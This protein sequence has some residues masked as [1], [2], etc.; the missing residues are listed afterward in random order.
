[1]QDRILESYTKDFSVQ[2]E[3]GNLN[4]QLLFSYFVNFCVI[5]RHTGAQLSMDNFDVDGGQ[6]MGLDGIAVLINGRP[7]SAKETVDHF[8]DKLGRLNVEFIFIQSKTSPKFDGGDLGTFLLGVKQFFAKAPTLKENANVA[9]Y[10]DLKEYIYDNSLY[11]D[12]P[13]IC[14][15][16]YAST[17]K[18]VDDPHLQGVVAA[19]VSELNKTNL[20]SAVKFNA[21]D[22]D[23]L[24]ATYRELRNKIEKEVIFERRTVLPKIER[25]KEAYLGILPAT[26][27][28][29]LITDSDGDIQRSLYYDN[30]RDFQGKN[31]VNEEMSETLASATSSDTFVLLNNGVTIVAKSVN[32]VG[33]AFKITDFQIVNGCQTSH[34]LHLNRDGLTKKIFVPVKLIVTDDPEVTNSIIK[35]TN[36]QTEVKVEAFESLAPFHR[37]LE[38]FYASFGKGP[39]RRLYY[40]RR[41]KQYENTEVKPKDIIS[42]ATQTKS[43]LAMF[44]NDPHSTPRYYG[45]LLESNRG[46]IYLIEHSPFVYYT[47]ALAFITID[48]LCRQGQVPG[49]C[50]QFKYHLTMLFR[51]EITKEIPHLSGKKA[52]DLCEKIC[53]VLWDSPSTLKVLN[54]AITVLDNKLKAF[55]GNHLL[56][57]RLRNF[58]SFLIPSLQARCRGKV[59]FFNI[60]RNFG[61]IDANL[62]FDVYV[63]SSEIKGTKHRYL[64]EDE[65]VEFDIYDGPT[66]PEALDVKLIPKNP[67]T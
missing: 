2:Y 27:F 49:W 3:L 8:R 18:W 41:S 46:K 62:G 4:P 55:K 1:M 5:S 33:D 53:K 43:F 29:K 26:E 35:A 22:C 6:D 13:P 40:E 30:V 37:K 60:S 51:L 64:R 56:A 38:E 67:P 42:L 50:R 57:P 36:R 54:S 9:S 20:F 15:L 34:V 63:N 25:V 10:R 17:G 11:M 45:E 19:S 39:E 24:K 61:F 52:D 28:L 48:S 7:V 14:R 47:A 65:L 21:W 44:L 23:R 66:G 58:T 12:A 31:P 16:F 59:K 32:P